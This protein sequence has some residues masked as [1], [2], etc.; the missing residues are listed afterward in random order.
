MSHYARAEAMYLLWRIWWRSLQ[1]ISTINNYCTIPIYSFYELFTK[2]HFH[3]TIQPPSHQSDFNKECGPEDVSSRAIAL[4]SQ[5]VNLGNTCAI[6]SHFQ[7]RFWS[8]WLYFIKRTFVQQKY[9]VYLLNRWNL[10][11]TRENNSWSRAAILTN[12]TFGTRPSLASVTRPLPH[13]RL[14]V[15]YFVCCWTTRHPQ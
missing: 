11:P 6:P 15:K 3:F 13:G 8:N 12:C 10:W 5:G 9:S 2:F 4:F 7:K 14:A 1:L